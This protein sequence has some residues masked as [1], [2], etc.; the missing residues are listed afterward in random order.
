MP[1]HIDKNQ[2]YHFRKFGFVTLE[3]LFSDKQIETIS[4]SVLT[5]L[6]ANQVGAYLPDLSPEQAY[7][8]GSNHTLNDQSLQKILMHQK[9]TRSVEQFTSERK[10]FL[11]GDSCLKSTSH[12][13]PSKSPINI[14]LS[15]PQSIQSINSVNPI[16]ASLL[17]PIQTQAHV[18]GENKNIE[19]SHEAEA[20]NPE[21]QEENP[22]IALSQI[23]PQLNQVTFISPQFPI[24]FTSLYN[25]ENTY[26]LL[27]HYANGK[28]Y[29]QQND[30]DPNNGF[31]K[32]KGYVF[33]D[34]LRGTVNPYTFLS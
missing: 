7:L 19:A 6:Q 20:S 2:L 32:S 27:V 29:Y 3:D 4:K 31:L 5:H 33:G 34:A 22:D 17:I 24:D 10:I 1:I 16:I 15:K 30:R 9:V 21:L 13:Q 18:E 8:T 28:A 11:A 23:A 25:T 14:I 26:Y 12:S